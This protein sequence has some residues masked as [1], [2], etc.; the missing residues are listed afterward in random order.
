LPFD[1]TTIM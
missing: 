1:R